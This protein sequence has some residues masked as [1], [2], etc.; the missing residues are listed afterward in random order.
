MQPKINDIDTPSINISTVLSD[1][2]EGTI[3]LFQTFDKIELVSPTA[4]VAPEC[5]LK[6]SEL[7]RQWSYYHPPRI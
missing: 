6:A 7:K 4:V 3:S 2:I 5:K 1:D